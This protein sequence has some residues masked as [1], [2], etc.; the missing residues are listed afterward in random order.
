MG[1]CSTSQA[2]Y[3]PQ[4]WKGERKVLQ[5]FEEINQQMDLR[6]IFHENDLDCDGYLDKDDL[7]RMFRHYLKQ[8]DEAQNKE[9][10]KEVE[11]KCVA[12]FM[13]KVDRNKDGRIGLDEFVRSCRFHD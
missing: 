9:N 2:V 3:H 6:V 5:Q 4:P 13:E 12:A 11:S 1:T 10:K 7:K 8:P